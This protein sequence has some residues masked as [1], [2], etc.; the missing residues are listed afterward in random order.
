MWGRSGGA[1]LVNTV[2]SLH[3]YVGSDLATWALLTGR[4]AQADSV[5]EAMLHWRSASGGA[6]ELFAHDGSYGN[7]L[8]PHATSAAALVALVRN[9]LVFDDAEQLILTA[10]A[11]AAWWRHGRVRRAPTRWGTIDLEFRRDGDHAEWRWTRVP[12]GAALALP[13]G[14]R[15]K[16]PLPAPLTPGP[17][18]GMVLAPPG[19]THAR[20]A[21]SA[22]GSQP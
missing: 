6:G 2:D 3:Y 15:W 13:P 14:T 12:V 17:A 4:R 11:R 7:N 8:P 9:A 22:A 16:D 5:L 10:G 19:T 18:P 20:V 21:L 1:G